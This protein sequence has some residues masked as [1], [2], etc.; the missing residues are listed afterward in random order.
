MKIKYYLLNVF[1]VAFC[2]YGNICHEVHTDTI[3]TVV[4]VEGKLNS[5]V[6]ALSASLINIKST[7]CFTLKSVKIALFVFVNCI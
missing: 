7:F 6:A 4:E 1:F 3:T 2:G 5:I